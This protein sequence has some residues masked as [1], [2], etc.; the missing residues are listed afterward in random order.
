MADDDVPDFE[1]LEPTRISM[2][3]LLHLEKIQQGEEIWTNM[4]AAYRL[5]YGRDPA[6]DRPAGLR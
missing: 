2:Q 5:I 6:L 3:V 1:D 4:C